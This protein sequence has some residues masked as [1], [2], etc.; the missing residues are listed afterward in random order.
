MQAVDVC[1]SVDEAGCPSS[2]PRHPR[3][4]WGRTEGGGLCEGIGI[5]E[6]AECQ[7]PS[8]AQLDCRG[9]PGPGLRC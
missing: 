8:E 9:T 2:A 4:S 6:L 1:E 5:R 3:R 7:R